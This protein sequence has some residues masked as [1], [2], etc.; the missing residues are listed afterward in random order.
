MKKLGLI[1]GIGPASTVDYYNYI[2]E[3]WRKARRDGNYPDFLIENINMSEMLS[4]L[5]K[6]DYIRL[7]LQLHNSVLGL[8]A[9]GAEFIAIASNTPHVV[10]NDL[11]AR[12]PVPIVSIVKTTADYALSR[13]YKK[14]LLLG[15]KFT[16][17]HNFYPDAFKNAG[18]EC[19]VPEGGDV[20]AVHNVIFPNLE[21]GLVIPADKK[22]LLALIERYRAEKAVDAVV[23]G[24]TELPIMIKQNDLSL[25]V[26]DTTRVHADAIVQFMLRD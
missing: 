6:G 10:I 18:V 5:D 20:E 14:V 12:S 8:V 13:G 15:T 19:I 21:E 2:I 11:Q 26:I 9:A 17:S 23:L 16:L 1:G 4:S 24:C 7:I 25:P 3:G 22:A